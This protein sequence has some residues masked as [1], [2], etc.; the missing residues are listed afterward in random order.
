MIIPLVIEQLLQLI[1]GIADTMMVS[2][3]GEATVSG[4]SLDTML[5]TIFIYLFTAVATGGAV[6]VSREAAY[7]QKTNALSA[8]LPTRDLAQCAVFSPGVCVLSAD[9]PG[10][11]VDHGPG[12]GDQRP[13][14]HGPAGPCDGAD[15]P[16]G[17]GC[18]HLFH[19]IRNSGGAW[20]GDQSAICGVSEDPDLFL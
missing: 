5:Y 15:G 8:W 20:S 13:G 14:L 18:G 19:E 10:D 12:R 17:G 11:G 16:A 7:A 6:I 3:A 9:S 1:V 2:Y 4:V